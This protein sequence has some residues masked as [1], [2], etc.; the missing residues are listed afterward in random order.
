MLHDKML[1]HVSVFI[2]RTKADL[3]EAV[4]RGLVGHSLVYAVVSWVQRVFS[5]V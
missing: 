5:L 2:E 3:M 1:L 4:E